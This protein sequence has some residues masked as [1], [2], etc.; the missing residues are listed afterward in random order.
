M[1]ENLSAAGNESPDGGDSSAPSTVRQLLAKARSDRGRALRAAR[2]WRRQALALEDE[3][4]QMTYQI[5][6]L[7][8]RLRGAGISVNLN[9]LP[10]SA[11]AASDKW[12]KRFWRWLRSCLAWIWR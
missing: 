9:E 10:Q 6:E 3:L 5:H 2:R 8:A 1:N 12:L 7:Q 4:R 11:A